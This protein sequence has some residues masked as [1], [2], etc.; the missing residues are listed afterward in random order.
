MVEGE[1]AENEK[2]NIE[3]V[4][5]FTS[6]MINSSAVSTFIFSNTPHACLF[7]GDCMAGLFNFPA[8]DTISKPGCSP[9]YKV[10]GKINRKP[11]VTTS[12]CK[13]DQE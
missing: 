4:P 10:I 1:R 11:I 12:T 3:H 9:I 6:R 13:A 8:L 5:V 7:S 2:Q